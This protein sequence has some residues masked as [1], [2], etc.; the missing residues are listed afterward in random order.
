MPAG[1]KQ[2]PCSALRLL[3]KQQ[4][5]TPDASP[6][7]KLEAHPTAPETSQC[8]HTL[9]MR[10]L[11]IASQHGELALDMNWWAP[12]RQC[13]TTSLQDHMPCGR[14]NDTSGLS[15]QKNP[16]LA[17]ALG[18]QSERQGLLLSLGAHVPWPEGDTFYSD[19]LW[20]RHRCDQSVFKVFASAAVRRILASGVSDRP[21]ARSHK[22]SNPLLQIRCFEER[23]QGLPK[24]FRA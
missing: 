13:T 21:E 7:S 22:P 18:E 16:T 6:P 2:I 10:N 15:P 1:W 12:C 9:V 8:G 20:R 19:K 11:R 3:R 17:R 4:V 23:L 5:P 14:F 24:L